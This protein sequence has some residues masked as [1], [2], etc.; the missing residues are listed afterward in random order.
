MTPISTKTD[1]NDIFAIPGGR[2]SGRI[3]VIEYMRGTLEPS[4]FKMQPNMKL[5]LA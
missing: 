5:Q 3:G 2:N 1:V 4:T